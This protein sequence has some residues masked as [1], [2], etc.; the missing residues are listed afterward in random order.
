[1]TPLPFALPAMLQI[2]WASPM[3]RE[4]WEAVLADAPLAFAKR[5]TDAIREGRMASVI[6]P[7]RPFDLPSLMRHVMV[8]GLGCRPLQD[9]HGLCARM[10][11][12]SPQLSLFVGVG[13]PGAI[14]AMAAA[15]EANEERAFLISAGWPACC[16]DARSRSEH[17][18][19]LWSYVQ[20]G[21]EAAVP[22]GPLAWHPLLRVLG[23]NRLPH[24]PCGTCCRPSADMAARLKGTEPIDE[25]MSWP[26]RW[27]ALHGFAEILSPIAKIIHDIDA[28][29]G[30]HVCAA[31]SDILPEGTPSGVVAPYRTPRRRALRTTKGFQLGIS[32]PLENELPSVPGIKRLVPPFAN[33]LPPEPA[34][35]ETVSDNWGAMRNWTME[36]LQSRFAARSIVVEK[37]GAT[38]RMSFA[39][40]GDAL[41]SGSA[42][43]WYLIDFGFD[44]D[45]PEMLQDFELPRCLESWHNTLPVDERPGLL[46]LYIGGAGSGTS[47]HFDLLYTCGFNTLISGRKSWYFCPPSTPRHWL[48][49][50]PDLFDSEVRDRL[51]LRGL[52]L[53]SHAQMP[54]E[55]LFVPS[56][57][58]HQTRI[59]ETSIALT[60]NIVEDQRAIGTP[61]V[62]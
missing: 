36:A 23:V 56:G 48:S 1:M 4:R 14:D 6:A 28:T 2:A 47:L 52:R 46:S 49:G 17:D 25:I 39:D 29:A 54:G 43:G 3:L 30:K 24:V 26:V 10:G 27:S 34:I 35:L 7:V 13:T 32:T 40:Y 51:R 53:Q 22:Q 21:E 50:P 16:A 37:Q 33:L 5:W 62:G 8:A 41:A 58:W 19:P 18:S 38:R 11:W 45:A 59:E 61:F 60:G 44:H 20:A 31:A 57:W 15:L 42:D 9:P 12:R 55:T